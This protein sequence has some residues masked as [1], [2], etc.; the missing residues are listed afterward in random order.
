MLWGNTFAFYPWIFYLCKPYENKILK[1]LF[2][3]A[4]LLVFLFNVV[5]YYGVYLGLR[6]HANQALKQKLDSESYQEEEMLTVKIPFALPYQMDWKGY[7]RID[8]GFDHNG[9][10]YKLVKH[11]V[12]RDTLYIMYIRDHQE[13]DLFKALVD[14]VQS[15]TDIPVSKTALKFL[16]NFA[17]DYIPTISL[18][19]VASTGWCLDTPFS[20]PVYSIITVPSLVYSPPPDH[21]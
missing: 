16:E 1:R 9:Q 2:S 12:E 8:G 17:K 15:N 5:G 19:Q 18:I 10:F 20:R 13:T 7:Q 14:I 3:I 11:K 4:L 21:L 6:Y